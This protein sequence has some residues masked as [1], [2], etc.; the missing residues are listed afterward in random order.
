MFIFLMS[1]T[2]KENTN[3]YCFEGI[4]VLYQTN[5]WASSLYL[6]LYLFY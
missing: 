2:E 6:P 5:L 4:H 1:Y 3:I